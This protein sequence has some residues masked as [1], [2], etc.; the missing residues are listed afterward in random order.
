M[1]V[2]YMSNAA[3]KK[4]SYDE[5]IRLELQGKFLAVER[6]DTMLWKIRSGYVATLYGTLTI[7]GGVSGLIATPDP[8]NNRVLIAAIVAI[9]AFSLC[10]VVVDYFFIKAKARV[11]NDTNALQDLALE[12]A[13]GKTS[14]EDQHDKLR[15]LL[16]NSGESNKPVPPHQIVSALRS[17]VLIYVISLFIGS[18]IVRLLWSR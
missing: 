13:I 1:S 7:F 15:D 17:V 18:A 9:V 3:P 4:L 12:I 16:H 2:D 8:D 6:Y 10:G 14:V 11:V 5:L